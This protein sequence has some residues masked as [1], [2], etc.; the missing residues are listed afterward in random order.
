MF[1]GLLWQ[2]YQDGL[3]FPPSVDH[4]LPELFIVTHPSWVALCG[5]AHSFIDLYKPLH[6]YKAV[7]YEYWSGLPF[8]SSG[9]LP[10]PGLNLHPLCFLHWQVDSLPTASPGKCWDGIGSSSTPEKYLFHCLGAL[11]VPFGILGLFA[12]S[13]LC[14]RYLRQCEKPGN[15]PPCHSLGSSVSS[16]YVFS[17]PFGILLYLLYLECPEFLHDRNSKEKAVYSIFLEANVSSF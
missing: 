3:P 6:H 17:S 12:S 8:P 1:M 16:Q 9:D 4:D 11:F 14:L 2:E 13:S 5:M 15:S 10:A 7:I